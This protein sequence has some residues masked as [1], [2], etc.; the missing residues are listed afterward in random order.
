[1]HRNFNIPVPQNSWKHKPKAI[2]ENKDI[3]LTYDLMIPSSV[4]KALQPDMVLRYYRNEE[5]ALLIEVTIP[6][7]FYQ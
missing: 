7:D 3:M 5:K 2:I 1:M 4:N 6:S